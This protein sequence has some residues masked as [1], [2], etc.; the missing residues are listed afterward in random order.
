MST[1]GAQS[2]A[3]LYREVA[4]ALLKQHR[5]KSR[6]I[7]IIIYIYIYDFVVFI[8]FMCLLVFRRN[9]TPVFFKHVRP[10][11]LLRVAISEGLTQ[12]NS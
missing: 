11:R 10:V 7:Y 6:V 3:P 1:S 2:S 9:R 12:A 8:L 5:S 4:G